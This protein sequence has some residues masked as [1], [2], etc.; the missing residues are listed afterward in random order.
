MKTLPGGT[1]DIDVIPLSFEPRL[2]PAFSVG[3]RPEPGNGIHMQ[4]RSNLIS[5]RATCIDAAARYAVI[6][7]TK[8]IV[9]RS[10]ADR[11]VICVTLHVTV[12]RKY[13]VGGVISKQDVSV[14]DTFVV[15][16]FHH[17]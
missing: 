14:M 15:L 2:R 16:N 17:Y 12:N 7:L 9:H 11:H 5:R 4:R 10:R 13:K 6:I 8:K 3:P 1:L